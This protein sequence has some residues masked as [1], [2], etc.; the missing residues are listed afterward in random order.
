MPVGQNLADKVA[1][2]VG[3]WRFIII[4]SI[5]LISWILYNIF[6]PAKSQFDP[7]PFVFL[8]LMLSFQAAYTAPVIMMSSNRK[9]EIDRQRSIDIH[10]LSEEDHKRLQTLLQHLDKHFDLLNQRLDKLE[11]PTSGE[12]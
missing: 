5:L 7:Y 11:V 2:L 8:N 9:E 12:F 4:Q 6:A 10:N 1:A 3:S